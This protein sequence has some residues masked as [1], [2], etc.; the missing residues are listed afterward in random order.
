MSRAKLDVEK[1]IGKFNTIL[2]REMRKFGE[3]MSQEGVVWVMPTF[4]VV[5]HT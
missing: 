4:E 1:Q 5:A 3:R 2:K